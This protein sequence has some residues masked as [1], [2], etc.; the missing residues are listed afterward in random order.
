MKKLFAILS[1]ITLCILTSCKKK[2]ISPEP[3]PTVVVDNH[4]TMHIVLTSTGGG[5]PS[6]V[7]GKLMLMNVNDTIYN[8]VLNDT[9]SGTFTLDTTFVVDA[10]NIQLIAAIIPFTNNGTVM[11]LDHYADSQL[12][13]FIDGN[14]VYLAQSALIIN[15]AKIK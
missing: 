3:C 7:E 15:Q 6:R 9:Y 5:T 14:E 1:L 11:D 8:R 13:V 4:S 12:K 10:A 2:P